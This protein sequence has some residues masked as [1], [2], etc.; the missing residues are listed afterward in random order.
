M[1][2]LTIYIILINLVLLLGQV[3][4]SAKRATDGSELTELYNEIAAVE[5]ENQHLRADYY[6]ASSVAEIQKRSEELQLFKVTAQ[7]Y[8]VTLPVAQ[9]R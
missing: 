4:L 8:T 9:A 1:K 7:F 2:K 3:Y 6:A 5:K